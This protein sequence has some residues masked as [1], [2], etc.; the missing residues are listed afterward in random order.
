MVFDVDAGS[1]RFLGAGHGTFEGVLPYARYRQILLV[2]ELSSNLLQLRAAGA[3]NLGAR[4]GDLFVY[5][6]PA[7][8]G[9]PLGLT[10]CDA[11]NTHGI[12]ENALGHGSVNLETVYRLALL[13]MLGK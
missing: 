9:L 10:D 4:K 3:V 8:L 11:L 2:F 7:S 1:L 12:P 6:A 5:L 13:G